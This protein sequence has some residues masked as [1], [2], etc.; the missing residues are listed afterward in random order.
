MTLSG[1]VT[2]LTFLNKHNDVGGRSSEK[3][4]QFQSDSS[5]I[6]RCHPRCVVQ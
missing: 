1:K 2:S 4:G 6:L 3:D 5:P